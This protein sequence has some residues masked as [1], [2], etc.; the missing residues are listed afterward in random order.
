ML[1]A[2][3]FISFGQ[4]IRY[5]KWEILD[6]LRIYTYILLFLEAAIE[7]SYFKNFPMKMDYVQDKLS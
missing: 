6:A 7:Y 5:W 3:C 1:F 4:S 2:K